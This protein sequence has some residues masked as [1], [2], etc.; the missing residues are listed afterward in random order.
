MNINSINAAAW[1]EGVFAALKE[2]NDTLTW[3]PE[4]AKRIAEIKAKG[5]TPFDRGY[6]RKKK[7]KDSGPSFSSL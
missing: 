2:C 3:T 4:Q 1:R 5:R 6:R 7:K